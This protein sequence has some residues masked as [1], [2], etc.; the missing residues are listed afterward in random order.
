VA[1]DSTK[2]VDTQCVSGIHQ[3]CAPHGKQASEKRSEPEA[4]TVLAV[5]S[6][7][8]KA[9]AAA[10]PREF[11]N[12][13]GAVQRPDRRFRRTRLEG[14]VSFPRDPTRLELGRASRDTSQL[15]ICLVKRNLS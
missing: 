2:L 14:R 1:D 15:P 4:V 12:G 11:Q 13:G 8:Q 5:R 9:G 3:T 10:P 7:D 6:E